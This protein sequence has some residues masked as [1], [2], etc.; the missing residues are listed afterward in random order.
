[1]PLSAQLR[2]ILRPGFLSGRTALITGA[3]RG[4]GREC[5]LALA[6]AGCNVA[7]C[8]KSVESSPNLPGTIHTVADEVEQAGG[9]ALAIQLDVTDADA[10]EAAVDTT[11]A[12]FGG[13][14][15]L[16]NNA[17][18]LWWEAR[19]ERFCSR[20]FFSIY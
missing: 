16:I 2:A 6:R 5:A 3:S 20:G 14:D 12:H 4:I 15:V 9:G 13:L 19:H 7:I 18:A 11:A 17:G 8:A 1:M 10:I